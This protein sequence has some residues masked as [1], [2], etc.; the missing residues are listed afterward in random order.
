MKNKYVFYCL[1]KLKEEQNASKYSDILSMYHLDLF[2]PGLLHLKKHRA[3][4]WLYLFWYVMTYGNY[5]IVYLQ[6]DDEIIHYTHILPKIFKL[7]F[8]SENDLEIGPSWTKEE[9]RG[10][11]IFPSV[12]DYIVRSFEQQDRKFYIFAHADNKSSLKAIE[13]SSAVKIGRGY[14]TK[15][16]GIY[17]LQTK[18]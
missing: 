5:K 11:E 4:R 12:I 16:F 6:K 2:T 17:R 14:K 7:P 8:L 9:Y 15:W 13:K 3:N 18:S 10:K 1:H